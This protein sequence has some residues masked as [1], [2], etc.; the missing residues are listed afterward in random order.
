M[1]VMKLGL[2]LQRRPSPLLSMNVPSV[3]DKGEGSE[4]EA[5]A[6]SFQILPLG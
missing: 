2:V 3:V 5:Y 1:L 4:D 6:P